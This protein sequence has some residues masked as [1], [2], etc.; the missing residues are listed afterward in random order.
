MT[1]TIYFIVLVIVLGTL[2]L[3]WSFSRRQQFKRALEP[4]RSSYSMSLPGKQ[5]TA[6]RTR[7]GSA[8]LALSFAGLTLLLSPQPHAL[9]ASA[10]KL[11][12]IG[13]VLNA[14]QYLT[15]GNYM[16]AANGQY[17]AIMQSDGFF[18]VYRGSD[19]S[20]NLGKVWC[21]KNSALLLPT[22]QYFAIMKSDGNFCT[23]E[24][25]GPSHILSA[26]WCSRNSALPTGQYFA[27]MQND[28]NFCIYKGA[29][30]GTVWCSGVVAG[31]GTNISI[32][33]GNNQT[34]PRVSTVTAF[35]EASFAPLSVKLTDN[36]GNPLTGKQI[37]WSV[38]NHPITMTVQMLPGSSGSPTSTTD[39]N[40]VATL[41]Q[42]EG[43]SAWAFN[44]DGAF[45]IVASSG[46]A[47]VTFNL[48]V[49][50]S[51]SLST[52]IVAGNN[53]SVARTGTQDPGGDANFAP[54]QVK[55]LN[56][57]GTPA[58]GVQVGFQVGSAP[59]GMDVQF[60]PAGGGGTALVTTD[61]NGIA[62]LNYM[63]GK[64]M[65][66]YYASGPFTIQAY[67]TGGSLTP[68]T[69]NETVSS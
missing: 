66:C 26:D 8:L 64:S 30:E 69:F 58:S 42:M 31:V 23:Y 63:G 7:L 24:G 56:A 44:A 37:S 15:S 52:T 29:G 22:G 46:S 39:A 5:V 1:P 13:Y 61:A 36:I 6:L 53:Q 47:S 32:V 41:N 48:T 50:G 16:E 51:P 43:S 18:C 9:A 4:D 10:Q 45:N 2:A 34:Q 59:P 35:A 67:T 65:V 20:N 55:V 49:G 68:V 28:A 60:Y 11:T 27:T 21:V 54:L 12:N 14:G 19:P 25:T 57:N 17:F 62:T 40:G 33:S 3:G 38:T